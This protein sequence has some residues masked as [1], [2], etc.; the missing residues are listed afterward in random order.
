MKTAVK[1]GLIITAGVA[2]WVMADHFL[3]HISADGKAALLTPIIFNLLQLVVLFFGIRARRQENRD[4]LTLRQGIRCGMAISLVYAIAAFIFFL[5][6]YLI[7]GSKALQ[8]EPG[9]M[10]PDR[11]EK[12]VL[13]Q[14][15]AGLFFG[16]LIAGLIYSGTISYGL[17]TLPQAANER[18]SKSQSRQSR[19]RG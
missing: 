7:V 14:A 17:K 13:M 8:N 4:R 11:P 10:N 2:L 6:F 16:V 12:Y 9:A 15:F 5:A 3:L 1:Y 19:R 18:Q